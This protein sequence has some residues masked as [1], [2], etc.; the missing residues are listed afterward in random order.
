MNSMIFQRYEIKYLLSFRQY[1][2]ILPVI[3]EYMVPDIHGKSSIQSLYFDTEDSLLIRRS[4]EKPEYKEKLRL[5]SY[6][7]VKE[8]DPVFLEIKKKSGGIV[9]KRRI[10]LTEEEAQIYIYSYNVHAKTQIG[11]EIAYFKRLYQ[12]LKP[13]I[14]LIYDRTAYCEKGGA[15]RITFDSNIR[16]RQEAFSLTE[17]LY[18]TRLLD[19]EQILMEVKTDAAIPLWL[20]HLLCRNQIFKTNFSKYGEAYKKIMTKNKEEQAWM[21]FSAQY[22]TAQR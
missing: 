2:S 18:G 20:S 13:A 11:K 10:S 21:N 15:L 4:L 7:L 17:G 14:L 12:S 19:E 22:L 8:G 9:Y 1:Q 6:G 3:K 16:Y 5:R